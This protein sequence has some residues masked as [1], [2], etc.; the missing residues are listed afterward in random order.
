MTI[1]FTTESI[2]D[3]NGYEPE[4]KARVWNDSNNGNSMRKLFL[5]FDD[6]KSGF[7]KVIG[8]VDLNAENSMLVNPNANHHSNR[9]LTFVEATGEEEDHR[10][11]YSY[12]VSN[13]K[14]VVYGII[15]TTA[16]TDEQLSNCRF[17]VKYNGQVKI[18]YPA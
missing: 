17:T 16:P 5:D 12:S 9:H 2:Q 14:S 6:M 18:N 4:T 10:G 8:Y 13:F 15:G 11:E 1:N 3:Y 7:F